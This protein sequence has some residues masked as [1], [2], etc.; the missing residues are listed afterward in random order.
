MEKNKTELLLHNLIIYCYFSE[1]ISM[2]YL[3]LLQKHMWSQIITLL[4]VKLN[5]NLTLVGIKKKYSI[6]SM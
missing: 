5:I 3:F 1:N 6:S 2:P 4:P